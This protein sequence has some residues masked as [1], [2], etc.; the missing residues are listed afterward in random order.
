MGERGVYFVCVA[1]LNDKVVVASYARKSKVDSSGVHD[2]LE[3]PSLKGMLPGRK[4]AAPAVVAVLAP[5][6]TVQYS[7]WKPHR[8]MVD[9]APSA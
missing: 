2:M 9:V 1:R 4:V 6:R 8:S 5:Y 3:Q 7:D